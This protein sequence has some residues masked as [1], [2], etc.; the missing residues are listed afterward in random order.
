MEVVVFDEIED[1]LRMEIS[2]FDQIEKLQKGYGFAS[3]VALDDR[4]PAVAFDEM[5]FPLRNIEKKGEIGFFE[6]DRVDEIPGADFA[7]ERSMPFFM[8]AC[9]GKKAM[10]GEDL[11][12]PEGRLLRSRFPEQLFKPG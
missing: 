10:A 6:I 4:K 8:R 7:A 2:F 11:D 9:R 3:G 5:V 12:L 1:R